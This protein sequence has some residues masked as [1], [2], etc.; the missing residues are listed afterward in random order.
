MVA[1]YAGRRDGCRRRALPRPARRR[2]AGPGLTGPRPIPPPPSR[3]AWRTPWPTRR[4]RL[5]RR[6][7]RRLQRCRRR[8]G[9]PTRC[10]GSARRAG[11]R[12]AAGGPAGRPLA[13]RGCIVERRLAAELNVNQAPVREALRS[14]QTLGLLDAEPSR[15]VRV[16]EIGPAELSEV[17]QVRA[18]LEQP[19]A[20]AAVIRLA[21]NT[22]V[23]ERHVELMAA[24]AAAG[25]VLGQARHVTPPT[26]PRRRPVRAR[27]PRSRT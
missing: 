6:L 14:L 19:A 1:A 25:D 24:A 11:A 2:R 9:R 20:E 17:Y 22:G 7:Q 4:R 10:P 15:G 26:W 23:L 3:K 16:R 12:T 21:G 8:A 5:H 27:R 18:A 13:V